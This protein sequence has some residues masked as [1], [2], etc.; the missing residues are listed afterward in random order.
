M[1]Y[2]STVSSRSSANVISQPPLMSS[3]KDLMGSDTLSP[4]HCKYRSDNHFI[5]SGSNPKLNSTVAIPT[6]HRKMYLT[7]NIR[8]C[9]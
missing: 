7:R 4:P 3:G 2:A 8:L 6:I 5:S 9:Y 1:P